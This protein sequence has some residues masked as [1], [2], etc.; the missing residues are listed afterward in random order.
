LG[1]ITM[2]TWVAKL[3]VILLVLPTPAMVVA[4]NLLRS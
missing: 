1:E 3:I 2:R 4:Y